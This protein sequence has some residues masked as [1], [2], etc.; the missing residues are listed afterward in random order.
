VA[1]R[2]ATNWS[3]ICD[4]SRDFSRK[5]EKFSRKCACIG[6]N[7]KPCIDLTLLTDYCSGMQ[8]LVTSSQETWKNTSLH[9][10]IQHYMQGD[11]PFCLILVLSLCCVII[12][13]VPPNIE[14]LTNRIF[15]SEQFSAMCNIFGQKFTK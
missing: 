7:F 9:V 13:T 2:L 11:W 1:D 8:E 3:L 6:R 14:K 5:R 15:K 10:Q 12:T 4:R